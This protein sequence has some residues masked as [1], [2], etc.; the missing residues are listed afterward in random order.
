LGFAAKYRSCATD[1]SDHLIRAPSFGGDEVKDL[2]GLVVGHRLAEALFLTRSRHPVGYE[3][4]KALAR[5]I[6][7]K[8]GGEYMVRGEELRVDDD[9]LWSPTRLVIISFPDLASANAFLD[10]DEYAPVKEMR[11]QYAKST[12]VLVDGGLLCAEGFRTS[13]AG[14]IV[15]GDTRR[16][17]R[18]RRTQLSALCRTTLGERDRTR[19]PRPDT[20]ERPEVRGCVNPTSNGPDQEHLLRGGLGRRYRCPPTAFLL[21]LL[22]RCFE[23]Y[24]TLSV[25]VLQDEQRIGI[26]QPRG[27]GCRFGA[28]G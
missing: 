2:L 17:S 10:S 15:R 26:A 1:L 24:G 5:P 22:R 3:R 12:M 8:I 7:E 19:E 25:F 9:D 4:Y 27:D 14:P 21:R 16:Q 23:L 20:S 18:V 6:A 13:H 28:F 11:R